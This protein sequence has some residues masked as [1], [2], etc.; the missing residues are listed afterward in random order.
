MIWV[1]T[2]W[3]PARLPQH[4][5]STESNA[6]MPLVRVAVSWLHLAVE[7]EPA[8]AVLIRLAPPQP[9]ALSLLYL[10]PK[11]FIG[12]FQ[13]LAQ[14]R[15]TVVILTLVM[16]RAETNGYNVPVTTVQRALG[17]FDSQ[18]LRLIDGKFTVPAEPLIVLSA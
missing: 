7:S 10:L 2:L 1:Y 8:L 13:H 3:N 12:G 17:N 4:L 15:I 6:V 5:I 11:P 16:G 9:A 14:F 18:G